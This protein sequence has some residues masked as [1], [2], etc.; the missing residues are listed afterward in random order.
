[1][2]ARN[3]PA[4]A[5]IAAFALLFGPAP[6]KSEE[7][8]IARNCNSGGVEERL[9]CLNE[10]VKALAAENTALKVELKKKVDRAAFETKLT[11]HDRTIRE[12]FRRLIDSRIKDYMKIA[13]LHTELEKCFVS[14]KCATAL[15]RYIAKDELKSGLVGYVMNEHLQAKL[16]EKA[17]AAHVLIGNDDTKRKDGARP[18]A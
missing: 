6:V 10:S 15:A 5:T 13:E 16:A 3:W 14:A 8:L 9:K 17:K 7:A 4:G 2:F 18:C 1:M 11:D 12:D